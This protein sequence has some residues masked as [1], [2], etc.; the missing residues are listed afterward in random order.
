VGL[1]TQGDAGAAVD[2]WG[3]VRVHVRVGL[4]TQ[5]GAG[6][7]AA[8]WGPAGRCER[9][10]RRAGG[11]QPQAARYQVRAG[12]QGALRAVRAP[13]HV[14]SVRRAQCQSHAAQHQARAGHRDALHAVRVLR[15]VDTNVDG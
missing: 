3:G 15:T 8:A 9:A 6:A 13:R 7:A 10:V 2:P 14:R 1:C 12:H 4:C 11:C 5:G